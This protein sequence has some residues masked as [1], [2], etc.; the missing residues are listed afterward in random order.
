M[1][2]GFLFYFNFQIYFVIIIIILAAQALLCCAPAFSSWGE[3]RGG[4]VQGA[5]GGGV[6]GAPAT[7]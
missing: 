1:P 5:L 2:I 7:V 6:R 4:G 3:Q